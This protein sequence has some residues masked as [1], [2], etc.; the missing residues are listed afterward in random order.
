MAD[1]RTFDLGTDQI[2]SEATHY[3]DAVAE[4]IHLIR[5][6]YQARLGR[7][8][9]NAGP[10]LVYMAGRI[11]DYIAR[12]PGSAQV[13]IAAYFHRDKGQIAKVVGNLRKQE[14]I[15]PEEGSSRR[16]QRLVL[17]DLGHQAR[18]RSQEV[19]DHVARLG[20]AN[21]DTREQQLLINLLTKMRRNLESEPL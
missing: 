11:L 9:T 12:N 4:Q 5:R 21:L 14:L 3:A 7:A 2:G 19:R 10:E 13:E 16:S 6:L 20:V 18:L 8:Y 1:D 15:E 17:T